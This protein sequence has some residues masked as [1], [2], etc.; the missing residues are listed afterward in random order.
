MA[1][2]FTVSGLGF[3][4]LNAITM[5][6]T[7]I[8]YTPS[9]GVEP[10]RS[11]GD[12]SPSMM[13][14]AGGR[15]VYRFTAPLASV[16]GAL[17]SF[18]PVTLSAFEMHAAVFSG[19]NRQSSGATQVKLDTTNGDAYAVI[20]AI[21]PTGGSVPVIM[22]DVLV[23]LCSKAGLIDPVTSSTGALPT[24]GSTPDLHT[25]GPM[26]DNTSTIWGLRSWRIDTGVA[27]EP[28]QADGFFYPTSYRQ[29]AISASATMA[30][31]DIV[32]LY[33][34]LTSDGKDATGAGMIF[35]ARAYNMTTK[36]LT[37][38]GYSFTFA[39]AFA[40]LDQITLSGTNQAETGVTVAA[41]ADPGTLTHPIT[42]ATSATLPT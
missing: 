33:A 12:L 42:V 16:W 8:S 6:V 5:P 37:T 7:D 20:S 38:T 27:M 31:A 14:R 34:A 3:A 21:Y 2:N 26:V 25:T 11:G 13:R 15:P 41:Y 40:S 39:K 18:L 36:V 35:Y 28:I 29:G 10:F 9:L 32:A 22:C 23:Y 24:L 1:V 4:K 17:A 19:P 30:H